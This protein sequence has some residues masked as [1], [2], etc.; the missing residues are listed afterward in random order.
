MLCAVLL[1]AGA[2]C[3]KQAAPESQAAATA[4][5]AP[6]E[7]KTESPDPS[8][9]ER[10]K[11]EK[12]TGDLDGMAERRFI[13]VLV[14]YNRTYYFYDGAEP[15]GISYE[16][17][18]EFEK[19]LNQKLKTGNRQVSIIFIPVQRGELLQGLLDGRGDIAA[20]NIGITP[21]GQALVDFSD[22]LRDNA[23]D[24]V[25]TGPA[26]P[27]ISS[28]DDLAGKEVYVRKLSRYW[29]T[30]TRFNDELKKSGKPQLILKAADENLDD[31]DILEMVNAGMVGITVVD[32][33]VGELWAKAF[34]ELTLHPDLNVATNVSMGWAFRKNSPQ[35]AA[36]VNE[37]VKDHRLGT[38]FGNTLARRYFQNNKWVVN[39][40]SE[41]EM[42][43]FRQTIEFFKEYSGRYGFDW[44]MVAAQAYQ[45]SRLDQNVRS[46]AGAV[47]VMQIK[48]STAAGDP[49]NI[50]DV[51]KLDANV[52][53]GVKYMRF[54]MD[55]YFNDAALDRV[56]RGLFAF[57]SYNAGPNKI[58][59]LRKQAAA[60]GL[61]PNK[62]FNNVELIVDREVGFETVTY[63][64]NIYKYY[65]AFKL[66]EERNRQKKPPA[67]RS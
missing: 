7:V 43:K 1:A 30:L 67:G 38:S 41:E 62:W 2:G 54:M 6:A 56:N 10:I 61:D 9:V 22:P 44:L 28:L 17:L 31:E 29:F 19:F 15:R 37:F 48:P 39:S 47:G 26:A 59:R 18:K 52:H 32:N 20:S 49:I 40:T 14:V 16:A 36:V 55:Q 27:P 63:V 3:T 53:A 66:A 51:E 21:E 57:A 34:K 23:S 35:L 4:P 25:V 65:V 42:K 12:W 8:V 46:S 11:H 58:A 60:E 50:P 33:L 45:E 64:S 24:I 13:R 5:A